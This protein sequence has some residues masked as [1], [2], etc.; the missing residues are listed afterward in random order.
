MQRGSNQA[1]SI[2]RWQNTPQRAKN[3]RCVANNCGLP[4][5]RQSDVYKAYSVW[6]EVQT[7]AISRDGFR[8][9]IRSYHLASWLPY[10]VWTLAFTRNLLELLLQGDGSNNRSV[11]ELGRSAVV[12]YRIITMSIIINK[13]IFSLTYHSICKSI[14]FHMQITR[15]SVVVGT[16]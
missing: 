6:Q 12:W 7:S 9:L 14:I 1:D 4:P 11:I 13:Y 16:S 15:K 8:C 5:T 10:E 2:R 3:W